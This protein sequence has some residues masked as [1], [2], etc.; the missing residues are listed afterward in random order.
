MGKTLMPR[1]VPGFTIAIAM[2]RFAK[3]EPSE[4]ELDRESVPDSRLAHDDRGEDEL[5]HA[6]HHEELLS[7]V[8]HGLRNGDETVARAVLTLA[9]CLERMVHSR[10]E[11]ELR[12]WC[13]RCSEI[14]DSI[15]PSDEPSDEEEE[16][17]DDV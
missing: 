14:S 13:A 10:N 17:K 9:K 7:R 2:P 4:D 15:P 1:N 8:F 6:P 11:S 12:K 5:F 3:E 16:E